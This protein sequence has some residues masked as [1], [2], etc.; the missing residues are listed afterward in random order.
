MP[1][2]SL[3]CGEFNTHNPMFRGRF[4]RYKT[5]SVAKDAT[6]TWG[7]KYVVR[8]AD[9]RIARIAGLTPL[10]SSPTLFLVNVEPVFYL[11]RCRYRFAIHHDR[12]KSDLSGG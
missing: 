8:F 4:W 11:L 10:F 5:A 3:V 2:V 6:A 7:Y 1:R 9:S 12:L